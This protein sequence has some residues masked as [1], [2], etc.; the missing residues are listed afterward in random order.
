MKKVP[1]I[2]IVLFLFACGTTQELETKLSDLFSVSDAILN[3][4][5]AA[6]A[7][8]IAQDFRVTTAR[9]VKKTKPEKVEVLRPYDDAFRMSWN[10]AYNHLQAWKLG[11]DARLDF[12]N[13][14]QVLLDIAL[15]LN[16][17]RSS[18]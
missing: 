5:N 8:V 4:E 15:E 9:I 7:L 18:T 14:Y 13:E 10:K 12:L 11:K 3:T 6:R 16:K 2:L 17:V 1:I